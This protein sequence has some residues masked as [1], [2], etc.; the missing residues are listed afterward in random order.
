MSNQSLFFIQIKTLA[1]DFAN[2]LVNVA[3]KHVDTGFRSRKACGEYLRALQDITKGQ[4]CEYR[5]SEQKA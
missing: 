2:K 5:I 3:G 4:H 1:G